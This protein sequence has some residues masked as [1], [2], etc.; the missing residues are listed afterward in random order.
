[1]NVSELSFE[2]LDSN[3]TAIEIINEFFECVEEPSIPMGR[4]YKGAGGRHFA[5]YEF[6]LREGVDRDTVFEDENYLCGYEPDDKR[7]TNPYLHIN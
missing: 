7:S 4:I 1:M 6:G 5:E 3:D 2:E